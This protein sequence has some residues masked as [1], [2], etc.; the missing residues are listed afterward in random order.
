MNMAEYGNSLGRME[1][2]IWRNPITLELKKLQNV[3]WSLA[4]IDNVQ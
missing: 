4:E 2:E 3:S 1:L